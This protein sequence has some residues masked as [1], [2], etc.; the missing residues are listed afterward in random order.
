M[1]KAH[2]VFEVATSC[3]YTISGTA[4]AVAIRTAM[5]ECFDDNGTLNIGELYELTCQLERIKE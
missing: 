4:L 5:R 2:R 1:E 3:G